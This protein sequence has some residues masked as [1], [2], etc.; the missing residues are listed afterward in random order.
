MATLVGALL[1]LVAALCGVVGAGWLLLD[2]VGREWDYCPGGRDCIAGWKMGAGFT[3]VG[4][5]AGV[6]A[7]SLLRRRRSAIRA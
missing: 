4:L 5:V 6:L 2:A 3:F 7:L 1:F